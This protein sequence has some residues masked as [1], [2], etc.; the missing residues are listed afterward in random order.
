MMEFKISFDPA[1]GNLQVASPKEEK[2][3]GGLIMQAV[4]AVVG[5]YRAVPAGLLQR[6]PKPDYY[7]G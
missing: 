7:K 2:E 6:L 5:A 3:L 4:A 1:T